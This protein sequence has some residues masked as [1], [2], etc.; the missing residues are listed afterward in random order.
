M[1]TYSKSHLQGDAE[2]A[3]SN[4]LE[5]KM[6]LK[7]GT[8]SRK[9]N[10]KLLIRS[11]SSLAVSPAISSSERS[12]VLVHLIGMDQAPYFENTALT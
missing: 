10:T 11:G 7:L 8:A 1:Q 12:A 2:I 5:L 9:S 4:F 3:R 6:K